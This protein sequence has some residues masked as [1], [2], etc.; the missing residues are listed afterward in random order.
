MKSVSQIKNHAP[1]LFALLL[2]LSFNIQIAFSQ[3]LY[4]TREGSIEINVIVKDTA[5]NVLSSHLYA[6][7]NY[8]TAEII[9]TV[10][11]RTLLSKNDSLNMLLAISG[12]PVILKGKLNIP[13]INT[14][15]HA[16]QNLNFDAELYLNGIRKFVPVTGTLVHI[17]DAQLVACDLSLKFKFLLSDFNVSDIPLN[18]V[19]P[20]S[21]EILQA[22]LKRD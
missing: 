16:P 11:P 12:D 20:I 9:L 7:I 10:D 2:C 6:S 8:N 3:Q 14:H 17:A 19:D 5:V 21:V 18:I 1:E 22:I 15:K 4:S 13:Y